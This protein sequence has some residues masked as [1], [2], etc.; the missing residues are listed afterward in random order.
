M[1]MTFIAVIAALNMKA[2]LAFKKDRKFL[3]I[4]IKET[5]THLTFECRFAK[6]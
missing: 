5:L 3:S 4:G 6:S 1:V 2:G